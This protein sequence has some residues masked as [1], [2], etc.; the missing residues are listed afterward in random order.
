[1]GDKTEPW[2]ALVL[3]LSYSYP[4]TPEL[5]IDLLIRNLGDESAEVLMSEETISHKRHLSQ[6]LLKYLGNI[7]L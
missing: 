4:K 7:K 6:N 5:S 3:L 1:M 2:G